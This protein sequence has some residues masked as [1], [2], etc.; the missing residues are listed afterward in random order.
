M[1][2]ITLLREPEPPTLKLEGKLSGAWV[3]ELERSWNEF[4]NE[5]LV[6]P[7]EVDLS[8]VTFISSEGKRLLKSML[9]QGADLQS[10][11]LMPAFII[12]Q[13]KNGSNRSH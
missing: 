11:S 6:R 3:P 13:I 7:V 9:H 2:K 5:G 12:N 8:D 1:L 4:L 10:R